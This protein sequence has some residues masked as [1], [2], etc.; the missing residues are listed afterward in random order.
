MWASEWAWLV[1]VGCGLTAGLLVLLDGRRL[2]VAV[3]AAQYALVA[4]L[5][6][7]SL[8]VGVAGAKLAAGLL[9]TMILALTVSAR[10]GASEEAVGPR[11]PTGRGFRIAGVLLVMAIGVGLGY[12]PWSLTPGLEQ[13]GRLGSAF[14]VTLGL[15]HLGTTEEPL[16][17]GVGLLTLLA[18]FEIPYGLLEP[19]LAVTAMLAAVHLGTAIVVSYLLLAVAEKPGEGGL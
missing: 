8:P 18:G 9:T 12:R 4:V 14:L 13:A 7:Q 19:S 16:R 10:P 17:V 2:L 11:L 1:G 15:F 3:L 5:V 6:A